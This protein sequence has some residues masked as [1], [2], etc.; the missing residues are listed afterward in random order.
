MLSTCFFR[1]LSSRA[2]GLTCPVFPGY[3]SGLPATKMGDAQVEKNGHKAIGVV[4]RSQA[5][6]IHFLRHAEGQSP[7]DLTAFAFCYVGILPSCCCVLL[8][9]CQLS[10][11]TYDVD[12]WLV[13]VPVQSTAGTAGTVLQRPAAACLTA[14]HLVYAHIEFWACNTSRC[15]LYLSC[16]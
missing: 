2:H 6:T 5:K 12:L 9:E 14:G 1:R 15:L 10:P 4:L 16:N 11:C 3:Y 7:P 13:L 8:R